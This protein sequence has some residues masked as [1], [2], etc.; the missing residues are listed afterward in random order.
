MHTF[1]LGRSLSASE[2]SGWDRSDLQWCSVLFARSFTVSSVA[3]NNAA[4]DIYPIGI[5]R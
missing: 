2:D 4:E 3:N 1:D 5:E